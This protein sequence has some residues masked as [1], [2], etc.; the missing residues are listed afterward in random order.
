MVSQTGLLEP[1]LKTLKYVEFSRCMGFT[2]HFSLKCLTIIKNALF[3]IPVFLRHMLFEKLKHFVQI[4]DDELF[5]F[6]NLHIL[7]TT[8]VL[9]EKSKFQ[10]N[11]KVNTCRIS[12]N[13]G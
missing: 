12:I 8:P 13:L 6:G 5:P 9:L 4:W 1:S 11:R 2:D 7:G 3:T 10:Y